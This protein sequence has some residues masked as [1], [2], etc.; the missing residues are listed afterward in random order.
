MCVY[1]I[2]F[3]FVSV[4][5]TIIIAAVTT[6]TTI[7]ENNSIP[8]T[9]FELIVTRILSTGNQH[10]V[11]LRNR[12]PYDYIANAILFTVRCVCV[13]VGHSVSFYVREFFISLFHPKA[14]SSLLSL[15]LSLLLFLLFFSNAKSNRIESNCRTKEQKKL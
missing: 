5:I 2:S 1:K 14:K 13:C 7:K 10:H 11:H 4:Q 15:S 8:C 3:S 9:H 6:T 12:H